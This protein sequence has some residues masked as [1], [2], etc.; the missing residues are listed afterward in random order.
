MH[1]CTAGLSV[2]TCTVPSS[3]PRTTAEVCLHID[4]HRI[5][6]DFSSDWNSTDPV[7]PSRTWNTHTHTHCSLSEP[8]SAPSLHSNTAP[9]L[10]LKEKKSFQRQLAPLLLFIHA[11]SLSP[12]FFPL[13]LTCSLLQLSAAD[14]M[15]SSSLKRT[16]ESLFRQTAED[17]CSF[18][19]SHS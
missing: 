15:I 12:S 1:T 11:F 19:V 10:T 18:V 5:L 4:V 6:D 16:S 17:V 9:E 7:L 8:D 14:T 3:W 13:Q 2:P